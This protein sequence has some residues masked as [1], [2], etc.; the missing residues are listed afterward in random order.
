MLRKIIHNEIRTKPIVVVCSQIIYSKALEI[1]Q[2]HQK[3]FGF[4]VFI[5]KRFFD[6]SL[7]GV[8]IESGVIPVGTVGRV[9][10]GTGNKR[11]I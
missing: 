5:A 6:A 9:L 8:A 3:K 4:V 7:R 2:K 1:N 10:N 11:E